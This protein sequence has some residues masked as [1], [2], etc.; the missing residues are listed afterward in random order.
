[1]AKANLGIQQEQQNLLYT[2]KVRSDQDWFNSEASRDSVERVTSRKLRTSDLVK[3][4]SGRYPD[5]TGITSEVSS[6]TDPGRVVQTGSGVDKLYHYCIVRKD[7]PFGVALA[8]TVHAA[9]ESAQEVKVPP[10]TCAVVLA[11][12]DE[13]ALLAVEKRLQEALID[14]VT[15]IR[16]PDEPYCG[17]LMTIGIKPQSRGKIRKLL[18]NLPLYR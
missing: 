18:S 1:M 14:G 13:T 8:Q 9:G 11:V 12:P 17:Q 3:G 4:N 15:S 16:E 6:P 7:L 10:N 5:R 2:G